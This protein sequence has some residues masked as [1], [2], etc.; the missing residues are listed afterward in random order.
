MR[1]PLSFLA[2]LLA[3]TLLSA[4]QANAP[5]APVDELPRNDPTAVVSG[6]ADSPQT[7]G[8]GGAGAGAHG[9]PAC[10]QGNHACSTDKECCSGRCMQAGSS[11]GMCEK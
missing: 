5:G 3:A 10:M 2:A 1:T 9:G 4:C 6:L 8:S 7:G 11:T